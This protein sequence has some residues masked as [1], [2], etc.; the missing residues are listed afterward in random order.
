MRSLLL[1]EPPFIPV[2]LEESLHTRGHEVCH[3]ESPER[4]FDEVTVAPPSRW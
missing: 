1:G 3:V 4:A 2:E